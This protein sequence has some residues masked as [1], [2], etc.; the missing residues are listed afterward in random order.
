MVSVSSQFLKQMFTS[1]GCGIS[2][3]PGTLK[4]TQNPSLLVG[5]IEQACGTKQIHQPILSAPILLLLC[6]SQVKK[7]VCLG[8]SETTD[9]HFR[10]LWNERVWRCDEE[11]V[12][13]AEAT[14]WV[15]AWDNSSLTYLV[16]R[17][18]GNHLLDLLLA[19]WTESAYFWSG[20]AIHF[21]TWLFPIA[22]WASWLKGYLVYKVEKYID[23]CFLFSI[24][25][26]HCR[27]K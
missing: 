8:D 12:S 24:L 27:H 18:G 19:F 3:S 7:C 22:A 21:P 10:C 23:P 17:Q 9:K 4:R 20:A 26:K 15:W 6:Y 2:L 1:A 11:V 5:K 13:K 14:K 16:Q 25:T